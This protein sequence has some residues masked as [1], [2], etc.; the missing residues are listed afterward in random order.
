M[1]ECKIGAGGDRKRKLRY[2]L[3]VD[4]NV[5]ELLYLSLLLQ[6]FDY[7]NCTVTLGEAAFEMAIT[8]TPALIVTDLYL[9][10]MSGL[11]LIERLKREPRTSALPVIVKGD[12][13]TF[14]RELRF[15]KAEVFA[16]LRV[17]VQAEDLFR[18]V[19][20]A[21]EITPRGN[22]RIR[23]RLPVALNGKQLN[24]AKGE[25][26]SELSEYGMYIRTLE[27]CPPY[28]RVFVTITVLNRSI[29]VEVEVLYCHH[30]G[31][32]PFR[33]PGMGLKF[34]TIAPQDREYLKAYIREEITK[35]INRE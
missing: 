28:A 13:L 4:S 17:P 26:V 27:P 22:I 2:V 8:A 23:T 19:Q 12:E 10:D 11:D 7:N 35:G 15:R 1:T 20:K 18:G 16:F 31:E 3:M 32:G 9:D 29:P 24:C 21:V 25:C 6:R 30:F 14:K 5:N 34:L 33:E